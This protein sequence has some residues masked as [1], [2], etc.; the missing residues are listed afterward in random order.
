[1]T[2]VKKS[3]SLALQTNMPKFLLVLLPNNT[4]YSRK[5]NLTLYF[6]LVR[7]ILDEK[8]CLSWLQ[9]LLVPCSRTSD[10]FTLA[11]FMNFNMVEI[12][13]QLNGVKSLNSIISYFPVSFVTW[14]QQQWW[15]V[16]YDYITPMLLYFTLFMTYTVHVTE[17]FE[18]ANQTKSHQVD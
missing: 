13:F 5:Y 18:S 14:L 2:G 12:T 9:N 10:F 17:S 6:L 3:C 15:I 11:W 1:M 16:F 4:G 8:I 7:W